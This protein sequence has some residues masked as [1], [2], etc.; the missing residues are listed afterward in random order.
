[1]AGRSETDHQEEDDDLAAA[2][3]VLAIDA[4]L[5]PEREAAFHA[6]LAARPERAELLARQAAL[7]G[8][9][10][11]AQ[12]QTQLQ[13]IAERAGQQTLARRR[14]NEQA[15]RSRRL[16]IGGA[17]AAGVSAFGVAALI[18]QRPWQAEENAPETIHETATG[19][20]RAIELAD[21]SRLWL[22]TRTRVSARMSRERRDVRLDAG[23]LYVEV[24]HAPERPFFVG[25]AHFEARAI[26][27]AFEASMFDGRTDVAVTEGVV[28]LTARNG[29]PAIDLAAGQGAWITGS[30]ELIR[31]TIAVR[32]IAAWRERRMVLSDRRL[33]AALAELSRYFDRPLTVAD[34]QLA[35]RRVSLS[36]SI[37]DLDEEGAARIIAGVVG[38]DIADQ[39]S[40]G[41][42][43]SPAGQ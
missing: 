5:E 43:L 23:R 42:L 14:A 26:G 29:G 36:F 12:L 2:R 37:A 33:D 27:T 6:W 8:L 15:L 25:G 28:R 3:W 9:A 16:F 18:T 1:V 22:D 10:Q 19:E 11:Q 41:I 17:I 20:V 24:A 21:T 38:A 35:A 39:A 31:T 13:N 30:G 32:S 7:P 34:E 40:A 4:G